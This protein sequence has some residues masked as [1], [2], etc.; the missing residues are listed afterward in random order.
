MKMKIHRGV[1]PFALIWALAAFLPTAREAARTLKVQTTPPLV[2]TKT[3]RQSSSD[4]V[5]IVWSLEE[6][7]LLQS[8]NQKADLDKWDALIVRYPTKTWIA[9]ARLRVVPI[10]GLAYSKAS[11][12]KP[13]QLRKRRL[14]E[15]I[16]IAV[17]AAKV[18][19]D[20][21]FWPWT[22]AAFHFELGQN[23]EGIKSVERIE[24]T[25]RLE[26][27]AQS[28]SSAR[29]KWWTEH[30]NP[31]WEER[32]TLLYYQDTYAQWTTFRYAGDAAAREV[33]RAHRRGDDQSALRI[34]GAVLHANDIFHRDSGGFIGGLIAQEN[35]RNVLGELFGTKLRSQ[36]RN[37]E[38]R[39]LYARRVQQ[40]W[41]ALCRAKGCSD[42][43][44]RA[45]W[46]LETDTFNNEY[47]GDLWMQAGLKAPWGVVGGFAPYAL[48]ALAGWCFTLALVWLCGV[49]LLRRGT[50]A[51][52]AQ[53]PSPTRGQIATCANFGFWSLATTWLAVGAFK[54]G[55][56]LT[57]LTPGFGGSDFADSP[58]RKWVTVVVLFAFLCWLL[59]VLFTN[60]KRG[61]RFRWVR[62]AK[63][64]R[65]L[66][67][68]FGIARLVAW[69]LFFV[70][71]AV[72]S[73]NGRGL[74]DDTPFQIGISAPL[75]LVCMGA[76]LALENVR[77]QRAG[78][79]IP[80]LR[81]E[82]DIAP[83]VGTRAW[84][85]LRNG[86]VLIAVACFYVSFLGAGAD[87][88]PLLSAI[89]LPVGIV[90]VG[91]AVGIN[92][93][94]GHGDGFA[95]RL[96]V[97]S[98]GVLSLAFSLAFVLLAL[99]AW[100]IRAEMNRQLAH[101]LTV[102]EADWIQEQVSKNPSPSS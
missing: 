54:G 26:D 70:F 36:D 100:P 35:G 88:S 94:L 48:L 89:G 40:R 62:S 16:G 23:A 92:R 82:G 50:Q 24:K 11:S 66:G 76:A 102:K 47:F 13:S 67:R 42:L 21:A 38:G 41:I 83:T 49:G 81:M 10:W 68:K 6:D 87:F 63:E 45:D 93:R 86:M 29:L 22:E 59:P 57:M 31:T 19:P 80:R 97:G 12:P 37:Y 32:S 71:A 60:W 33:A 9:A 91:A 14:A 99:G 74:W 58:G 7:L 25:K 51:S 75:A 43:A 20:N 85:W 90:A 52:E 39:Q 53:T 28:I 73:S 65:A 5:A 98:A 96:A 46:L 77:F 61:R 79:G 69:L 27:Y 15:A 55:E 34:A 64:A 44:G 84:Q 2:A 95:F 1:I 101:R 56:L 18:E 4:P 3:L 8:G 30:D 72:V 17:R 78:R